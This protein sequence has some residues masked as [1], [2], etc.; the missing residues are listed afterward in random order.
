MA[1]NALRSSVFSVHL[2]CTAYGMLTHVS[3]YLHMF[4]LQLVG[5]VIAVGLTCVGWFLLTTVASPSFQVKYSPTHLVSLSS[6]S[7]G[8][9]VCDVAIRWCRFRQS[10]SPW[11]LINLNLPA[12][13]PSAVPFPTLPRPPTP[14]PVCSSLAPSFSAGTTFFPPAAGTAAG[15]LYLPPW[16]VRLCTSASTDRTLLKGAAG[17]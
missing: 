7:F 4:L 8:C 9:A 3:R 11:P 2:T 10:F 5:D 16:R 13:L 14:L 1:A 17:R 12:L 15:R 6:D